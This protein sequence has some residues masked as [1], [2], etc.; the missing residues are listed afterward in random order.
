L[1]NHSYVSTLRVLYEYLRVPLYFGI[2]WRYLQSTGVLADTYKVTL[3]YSIDYKM[4]R[5]R[6]W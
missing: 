5:T 1:K 6:C 2:T 4:Y 3:Q